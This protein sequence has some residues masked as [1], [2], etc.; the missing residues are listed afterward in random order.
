MKSIH[1]YGYFYTSPNQPFERKEF[2]IDSLADD[3]VI[4]KIAGCGLCHTDISFLTGQVK[5]KLPPPLVLGHEISGTIIETGKKTKHLSGLNVIIPAVLPCG[6][7]EIC[8][9]GRDNVCQSQLMPGNDFHGGFATHIKV[10]ALHLCILPDSLSDIKLSAFS[11]VADAMTT[12]YQ[13]LKRSHLEDGD[14]A[15]IIGV[16][17]VGTYMV[18]HAKNIGATVIALDIDDNKLNHAKKMGAGYTINVKGLEDHEVKKSV[19]TLVKENELKKFG[20]KVFEMSGTP[21]GQKVGFSLLSF[22]GTLGIIGFTMEKTN[23]RLSN[24]MAFDADIFGNW[25]CSPKYYNDVV[26]DVLSKKINVIDNIEEY[27]LDKINE[28]IPQALEHKFDKR[29]IFTP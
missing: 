3:E 20:W 8:L 17:G 6:E 1:A 7:C 9:S 21:Q 18:Q 19:R 10:P 2:T 14:L 12:P 27:P 22:A 16:G 4:V 15:V 25:G 13:S 11:V 5:T 28:I 29:I 24:V 23:I 26:E